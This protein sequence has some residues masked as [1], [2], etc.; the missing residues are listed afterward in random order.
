MTNRIQ[1]RYPTPPEMA[2]LTAAAHRNRARL[3]KVIFLKGAR[4]LKWK[5][6]HV[7]ALPS[8]NRVSHA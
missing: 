6:A 4:A 7:V 5:F 2:A 3:M 1:F 8:G